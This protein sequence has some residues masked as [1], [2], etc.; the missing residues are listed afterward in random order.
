MGSIFKKIKDILFD[1]EDDLSN[2]EKI[3][4]TPEMR[5]EQAP[6]REEKSVP[7]EKNS[8]NE[9]PEI[10]EEKKEIPVNEMSER[11]LFKT[12][13]SPFMD[14][15]EEEFDTKKDYAMPEP[16]AEPPKRPS[17]IFEYERKK[18]I[19]KRTDYGRYEKTEITETTERK[20]FK[21][22]PIISPVYGILNQD[23]ENSDILKREDTGVRDVQAMR[24]KAFGDYHEPGKVPEEKV[25]P[26]TTFY[27]ETE[28]VT[29]TNPDEHE[30]KVKTID[31]LLEDT[32]DII[33]DID[34][35]LDTDLGD[36][37]IELPETKELEDTKEVEKIDEK[38]DTNDLFD[39]ID[40]M[41]DS[42]E[43]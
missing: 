29:I 18:K 26:K 22:S 14:F 23:Y 39:L 43:D 21:P 1:E 8:F 35:D 2:T 28:T 41:Y 19:E 27:E 40:A 31:E 3:T 37:D 5:N 15:D 42:K 4:I 24:D 33:V 32:S 16:V 36:M 6:S 7:E 25:E 13:N 9:I 34:K 12:N 10:K 17:N 38:E 30:R 20:K 11:D